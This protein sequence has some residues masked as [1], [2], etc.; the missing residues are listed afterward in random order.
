MERQLWWNLRPD[1]TEERIEY[2]FVIIND[3]REIKE[4]ST[5]TI[6]QLAPV[7]ELQEGSGKVGDLNYR[8]MTFFSPRKVSTGDMDRI[9][10]GKV[11][12]K[13][14]LYRREKNNFQALEEY[15]KSEIQKNN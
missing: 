9:Y 6:E 1:L 12:R 4:I 13:E 11:K 5:R 14:R 7:D 10:Q 8:L 3:N 15:V 2:F